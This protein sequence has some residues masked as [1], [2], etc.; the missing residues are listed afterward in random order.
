VFCV[1]IEPDSRLYMRF[2]LPPMGHLSR[3]GGDK[4]QS[5]LQFEAKTQILVA[6]R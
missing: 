2:S 4:F 5:F 6:A 3:N 1:V